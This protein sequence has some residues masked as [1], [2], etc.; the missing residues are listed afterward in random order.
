MSYILHMLAT[1]RK[2]Y[3]A[4]FI[5]DYSLDRKV[6]S[7]LLISKKVGANTEVTRA[8]VATDGQLL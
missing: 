4:S 8:T 2:H 3:F 6:N 5:D 7:N 1:E